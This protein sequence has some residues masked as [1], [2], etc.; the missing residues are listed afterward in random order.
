MTS[1]KVGPSQGESPHVRCLGDWMSRVGPHL[2]TRL[3]SVYH[4]SYHA[5]IGQ[6]IG[7]KF[8][9]IK[10]DINLYHYTVL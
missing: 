1:L 4:P 10:Q 6:E 5:L 3:F 9:T 8:N 7:I 2:R